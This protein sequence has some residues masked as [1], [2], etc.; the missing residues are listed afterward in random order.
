VMNSVRFGENAFG[1]Q[2]SL[3]RCEIRVKSFLNS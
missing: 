3:V 2:G 1:A